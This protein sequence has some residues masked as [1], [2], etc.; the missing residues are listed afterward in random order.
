VRHRLASDGGRRP[1]G[2]RMDFVLSVL[3]LFGTRRLEH[4]EQLRRC[5]VCA[6]AVRGDEGA[7]P[8]MTR[9]ASAIPQRHRCVRIDLP[10]T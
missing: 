1:I 2:D 4:R 6:G 10:L 3:S 9:L 8:A 5:A 7:T